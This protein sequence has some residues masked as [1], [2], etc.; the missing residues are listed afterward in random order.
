MRRVLGLLFGLCLA[1][2][3]FANTILCDTCGDPKINFRNYGAAVYNMMLG[4]R[5]EN[6]GTYQRKYSIGL[7]AP[8]IVANPPANT[9]A[10]VFI[11][12]GYHQETMIGPI[13]FVVMDIYWEIIVQ[14]PD[15]TLEVFKVLVGT[16]QL[17]VAPVVPEAVM[18]KEQDPQQ[19]TSS[20]ERAGQFGGGGSGLG[21]IYDF[22]IFQ[23]WTIYIG[24]GGG[25]SG[26]PRITIEEFQK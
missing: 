17:F 7:K 18:N 25:S 9:H 19:D 2:Q 8:V 13:P 22:R 21:P 24:S 5:S 16:D 15:G 3:A 4:A 20:M 23:P 12:R 6:W 10:T 14:A 11:R 1:Q 26:T